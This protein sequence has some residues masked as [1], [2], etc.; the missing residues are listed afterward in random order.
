MNPFR[1]VG[2]Q[3]QF[4]G[5][6]LVKRMNLK[7]LSFDDLVALRDSAEALIAKRVAEEKR[8]LEDRLSRLSRFAGGVIRKL[9]GGSSLKG[10][11]AAPKYRNPANPD[12]T[13]AG[14]GMKPRWLQ[15]LLAEGRSME[16]FAIAGAATTGSRSA[17]KKTGGRKSATGK[18]RAVKKARG[19]RKAA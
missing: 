10:R 9:T 17:A 2:A 19:A 11:K 6:M 3:D 7:T 12:E 5:D 16:E 15:A 8:T 14:R 4:P 13:W 18:K 1:Y